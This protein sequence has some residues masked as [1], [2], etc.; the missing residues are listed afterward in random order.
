MASSVDKAVLLFI[1]LVGLYSPV[2]AVSS[3]LPV[4]Q[5]FNPREQLRIAIGLFVNIAGITIVTVLLGEPLLHV[6]G[7]TTAA[8]SAAGGISLMIA[9]VPLMTGR[10]DPPAEPPPP[11]LADRSGG[12][13]GK[14]SETTASWRSVVFMPMTF[15]LTVGGATIGILVGFRADVSGVFAIGALVVAAA[16]YAAVTGVCVYISGH[17]QRRVSGRTR[18]LLDRV[19]G[20]LL[21]AIA[22]TLLA[23]GF[24]R[25]VI[26]V[27]HSVKIL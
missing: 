23:S 25:L 4:L 24:T 11:E 27:L 22:A 13:A 21:V 6:L 5:P 14:D 17:V 10:A 20:I 26:D 9:A 3:Y 15:P 19:A 18:V 16:A 1:A 8:L 12:P 2:A 7:L